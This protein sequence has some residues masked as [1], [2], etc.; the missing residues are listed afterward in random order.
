MSNVNIKRA[1]G[2]REI[3]E[4]GALFERLANASR[5]NPAQMDLEKSLS[6][7]GEKRDA[8]VRF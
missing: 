1:D 6:R 7:M 8:V 3:L 4:Q 2:V 5:D